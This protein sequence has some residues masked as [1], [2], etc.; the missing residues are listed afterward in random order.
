MSIPYEKIVVE[1]LNLGDGT[2]QVTMPGGGTSTGT[3]I[4]FA[5]LFLPLSVDL[6]FVDGT[7]DIGKS[8]ATRPR[9]GFFSRNLDV[10]GTLRIG[11]S[12]GV[13]PTAERPL[14]VV[15]TGGGGMSVTG[16]GTG[17]AGA[18]EVYY[19][20]FLRDASSNYQKLGAEAYQWTDKNV[21]DGYASWNVHA[22]AFTAG[23]TNDHFGLA[24]W[25]KHG[26]A[27]FPSNLLAAS[28]PGDGRLLIN[29]YVDVT[30]D[31][32]SA[33]HVIQGATSNATY[34][35]LALRNTSTGTAA[36]ARLKLGNNAS[37][38]GFHIDLNGG[39]FTASGNVVTVM[40]EFNAAM[41]FGINGVQVSQLD[42]SG[43][44]QI[45]GTAA[46]GTTP[47]TNRLDLFNGTAPV[48]TLANGVS[49]YSTSGECRVMDASGNATL[50]S[51]HD[52]E[53]NEWIFDSVDTVKGKRLRIDMER[54]MRRLDAE[55][56]GGYI[57]ETA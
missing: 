54:L 41:G 57:T 33:A 7:Y 11:A 38:V 17:A 4:N 15:G 56:G 14:G 28:A 37:A 12:A 29:G 32:T 1:D 24:F 35:C 36:K 51:P 42:I 52:A 49:L 8:G 30:Q 3:Q 48:G 22:T 13:A 19:T 31:I 6:L 25:A 53:S 27:F 47:G 2:V 20:A 16:D 46:R 34:D 50:L 9:D 40:Q 21:T 44:Y 18:E 10:V 55:F 45:G 26:A 43:S 23:V 5:T 39:N